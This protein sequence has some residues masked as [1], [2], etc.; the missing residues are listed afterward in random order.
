MS[1]FAVAATRADDVWEA[2]EI[3][4]DSVG[5]LDDVI[6]VVRD[7]DPEAQISLLFVEAD[8]EYLVILRLD[9]GD[10]ARVFGSDAPF[11][12]ES[13]LGAVLLS[14]IDADVAPVPNGDDD[15]ETPVM[16]ELDAQPVGEADLLSDLGVAAATLL[17]LCAKDG[18]LPSDVTAEVA[19]L[20]GCGDVVDEVHD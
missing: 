16:S 8:D 9:N 14:D 4:L 1:Y 10:D 5:D 6:D 3:D 2:A 13:R 17:N 19:S 11:A 18:M 20:I 15:L 12:E 7:V